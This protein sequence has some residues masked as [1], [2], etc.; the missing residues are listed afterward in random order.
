MS[1][2]RNAINEEKKWNKTWNGAE[3]L[4]T[5]QSAC[6]DMFGRAGAMRGASISDK[7]IMFSQ[8]FK[9]DENIAIKLLFYVRD[10]REGYGE[11]DTF[12]EMFAHLATINKE[13]V[14]KNLWA[15]LEFGR[16]KDLYSLIGTPADDDMWAFMKNQFELDL[17]NM[18]SNKSISLLAKWIATPDSK[19]SNTKELG[20]K[21]A[22]KLGYNY[23]TMSEYKKKL[24]S[25]RKY[26]DLPEAKMATGKWDEIEYSKCAS[27]FL[28]T[29]RSAFMRHDKDR[30]SNYID[31]VTNGNAKMNMGTTTPC[32][33]I[34]QVRTNYTSDLEAMWN[35]LPDVCKGNAM[36]MCDTSGSMTSGY[37]S[38]SKV[39]PIDVAFGLAMYFAQRN[40]GDLKDLMMNFSTSPEFI[41]LNAKTLYDNYRSAMRSPVNYSSTNLEAAF[42]LLLDTCI[43]GNVTQEDMPDAI[44]IVSDMQINCVEGIGRDTNLTFYDKMAKLYADA[45]Y[46]MPQV[47]FWNVNATNPTFHAAKSTKGVS[48]VSGYSPNI[49][50]QVMDNIGTTPLELMMQVVNSERYKDIIA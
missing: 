37:N 40:K 2:L 19:S 11:R 33:I 32:D 25:L 3:T 50:A 36:I 27:K 14:V 31:A 17:K 34:Y 47:V 24:R 4:G 15:V 48:L 42:M 49:F 5:T 30:Y 38:K 8:A 21:T 18:S 13:S 7:E 35:A 23:K 41:T 1:S 9:E 29:H 39:R 10:I 20:K 46:S 22:Q 43:R 26:L 45:G 44:V 12:N 16:A 6:L 28:L